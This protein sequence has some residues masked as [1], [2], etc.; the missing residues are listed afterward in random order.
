MLAVG[1]LSMIVASGL[2]KAPDG[3]GAKTQRMDLFERVGAGGSLYTQGQSVPVQSDKATVARTE[4]GNVDVIKRIG[5]GGSTYSS[6]Q[7]GGGATECAATEGIVCPYT[8][9]TSH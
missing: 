7:K 5:T 2:V 3:F 1:F 6:S 9:R 8:Q 4:R